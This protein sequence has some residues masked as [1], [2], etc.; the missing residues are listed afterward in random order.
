MKVTAT[1]I[2]A[3]LVACV[4]LLVLV[5]PLLLDLV[6]ATFTGSGPNG[7]A[8]PAT[9]GLA[10][11][12]LKIASHG[13]NLDAY[14]VRAPESC[15]TR[16]AL[17][18]FHGVGETISEWVQVQRLLHDA[19]IS[20]LIFDYSGNGD[21]NGWAASAHLDEDALAAYA[22][23]ASRFGGERLCV[24]G[25]SMGNAPMLKALPAFA[26][27]PQCVVVGSAYSS[28]REWMRYF[29]GLPAWVAKL[30]PDDWNNLRSIA[31]NRVPLLVL[32][33]DTD[34]VNP[35][36]MGEQI[37]QAAS[38]PKQFVLLRGLPHN[39]SHNDHYLEYWTPAICFIRDGHACP[40]A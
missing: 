13:R 33:S 9:A 20:S 22:L 4:L 2:A 25:F 11:E 34:L 6:E 21:S 7:P 28:G 10:F 16:T 27:R 37:Y 12:H 19:C 32:H 14:L 26:P 39:A 35:T 8:T 36:W 24:L 40:A 5:S 3:S 15:R 23:F 29:F 18:I 1:G 30:I 17:L 38:Q 31:G